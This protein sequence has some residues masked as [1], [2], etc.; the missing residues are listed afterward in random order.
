MLEMAT[1]QQVTDDDCCCTG[2]AQGFFSIKSNA[3]SSFFE[4]GSL[5]DKSCDFS[6]W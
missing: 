1:L 4:L 5:G 3:T 2:F 6:V